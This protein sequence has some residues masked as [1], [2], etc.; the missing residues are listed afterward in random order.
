MQAINP[1]IQ[2]NIHDERVT[3]QNV[4]A[5]SAGYKIIVDGSDNLPTRYLL[6]DY[7]TRN[8]LSLDYGVVLRF[9]GQVSVFWPGRENNPCYQCLFPDRQ[10][11]AEGPNCSEAGVLGVLP[12]VVG[13]LQATEVLKILLGTGRLLTGRLLRYDALEGTFT[14]TRIPSDPACICCSRE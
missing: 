10:G 7:C 3:A 14:E 5:L 4:A 9:E 2:I 6:N 8:R 12:A 11:V 1:N 13:S